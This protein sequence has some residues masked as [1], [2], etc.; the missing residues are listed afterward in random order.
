MTDESDGKWLRDRMQKLRASRDAS[1]PAF[2]QIWR[3]ARARHSTPKQRSAFPAWRLACASV[4]AV[5]ALTTVIT[6]SSMQRE[7]DRRMERD[8]AEVE[9]TLLTYWQAPSDTLFP[10]V[11]GNEA[12]ER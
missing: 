11:G 3:D 1:A 2:E 7:R 10:T 5:L 4:A 9:G 12:P 8:F 6:W